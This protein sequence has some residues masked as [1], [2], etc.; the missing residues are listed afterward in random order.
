MLQAFR[1]LPDETLRTITVPVLVMIGDHDVIRVEH[2][3]HLAQVVPRGELA[4]FP[5]SIH[6]TYLG[7]DEG[8]T[9]GTPPPTVAATMV[10]E[11]L[12]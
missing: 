10:E 5:G 9:P 11:F 1:D 2:A 7:A 6:G 3:V 4:V 8:V 12:H